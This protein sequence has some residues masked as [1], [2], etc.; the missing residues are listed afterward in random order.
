[1]GSLVLGSFSRSNCKPHPYSYSLVHLSCE[2]SHIMCYILTQLIY[3]Y[4]IWKIESGSSKAPEMSQ[5]FCEISIK[6]K[7]RILSSKYGP[8]M[9]EAPGRD[10]SSTVVESTWIH[11]NA[12][13][14]CF[15]WAA[16]SDYLWK[17]KLST[18]IWESKLLWWRTWTQGLLICWAKFLRTELHLDLVVVP[19]PLLPH[20]FLLQH[21]L[22]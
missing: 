8:G 6:F 21:L 17:G 10:P 20:C 3:I 7:S 5:L 1:M 14:P 4:H 15:P 9:N 12:M 22:Q 13:S 18:L 16:L 2:E 19:T 11:Q